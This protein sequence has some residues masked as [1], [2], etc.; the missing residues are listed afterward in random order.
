M[1]ERDVIG[2]PPDNN[3]GHNI[4]AQDLNLTHLVSDK[5]V[6]SGR[7]TLS[8]DNLMELCCP[9]ISADP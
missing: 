8:F 4:R 6:N 9:N 2:I 7:N 5:L 3:A 1:M